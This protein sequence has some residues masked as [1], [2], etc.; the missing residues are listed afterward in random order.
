MDIDEKEKIEAELSAI[1]ARA[2][3]RRRRSALATLLPVALTAAVVLGFAIHISSQKQELHETRT[4]KEQL[5][6]E[7]RAEQDKL[8]QVEKSKKKL[9]EETKRLE[10]RKKSLEDYLRSQRASGSGSA[11]IAEAH[12]SA[13]APESV[14]LSEEGDVPAGL[15]ATPR[16]RVTPRVGSKGVP[17]YDVVLSLDV[18]EAQ[19]ESISR[20]VYELNPIFYI[21]KRELVGDD[22]PTFEAKASVYACKSTV[23]AK[24]E[25]RDG[26]RMEVDFDWCRAEGW[27]AK[28]TEQLQV[29]EPEPLQEVERKQEPT[30]PRPQKPPTAPRGPR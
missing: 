9:E 6:A 2:R 26:S 12:A 22:A 11:K 3:V 13:D 20:V 17:V 1:E 15:R 5:D 25:L 23:L 24:I 10:E 7:L 16:A 14:V 30:L 18:P 19:K 8:D 29:V 28:K 4:V 27:P 21:T